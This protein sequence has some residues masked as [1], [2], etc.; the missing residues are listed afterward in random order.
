MRFQSLPPSSPP[1]PHPPPLPLQRSTRGKYFSLAKYSVPQSFHQDQA[2]RK[3]ELRGFIVN[4]Q[5]ISLFE[6]TRIARN[7]TENEYGTYLA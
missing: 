6:L 1:S 4:S 3:N 7:F 5:D 2:Q